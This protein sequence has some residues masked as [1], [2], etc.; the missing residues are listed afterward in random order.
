M[1]TSW[2]R[3]RLARWE[4]LN[5]ILRAVKTWQ[6]NREEGKEISHTHPH[7]H[8]HTATMKFLHQK[9]P[10]VII[11]S[12]HWHNIITQSPQFTLAFT[13]AHSMGFDECVLTCTHHDSILQSSFTAP[14]ILSSACSPSF[15]PLTPDPSPVSIVL[16]FPECHIVGII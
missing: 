1:D 4:L 10:S 7:P 11:S 8:I 6:K 15:P 14:R 5:F 3:Y 12:L 2:V 16:A 13:L 9:V